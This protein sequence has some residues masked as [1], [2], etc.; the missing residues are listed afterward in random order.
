[1]I[2]RLLSPRLLSPV[3]AALLAGSLSL[4]APDPA[5]AQAPE[6][7]WAYTPPAPA[8]IPAVADEAWPANDFDRFVLA[9]LE[10]I[11]LAPAPQADPRTLVRRLSFDLLGLP[12]SQAQVDAFRRNPSDAAWQALVEEL[13]ASPHH[14]ERL[15]THWF[16]LVRFAD[17]IGIHGDNPWNVWPYRDWVLDAFRSNKPFDE[18]TIEQLAGDL[19]PD[20]TLSQQVAAAYNRLNLI[21]RE[22]G[23]QPKEF[24]IRYTADRVRNVS[25]V[26]MAASMGCCECHDHKFDPLSLREFYEFGAFFADIEQVGVYQ[27]TGPTNFKPE[28][29]VPSAEQAARQGALEQ[30]LA[31]LEAEFA[32]DSPE[33]AS[34]QQ[35]FELGLAA[36][37][38]R[39]LRPVAVTCAT[40][41][42]FEVLDDGSVLLVGE[43]PEQGTF[44]V[45]CEVPTAE[46]AALRL[47]ALAD[48]SLP[49]GGPGRAEN[50]NLVL[51]EITFELAGEALPVAAS[52]ASFEQ[53]NY[54]L[55]KALDGK[56]GRTGWALMRDSHGSAA[57][58]VFD[59]TPASAPRPGAK[60]LIRLTQEYGSQH[61]LGRFRIS[62]AT[63]PELIALGPDERD[64]LAEP[65]ATRSDAFR[66]RLRDL[67]RERTPLLAPI[68]EELAATRAALEQLEKDIPLV[69]RTRAIV[70]P[71]E[72]RVRPRGN[73]MDDSGPVVAPGVPA[74][75]GLPLAS[76]GR[77]TRLDLARWL[78]DPRHPTTARVVVNRIWRLLFGRGIVTSLDDFGLQGAAPSDLELLDHLAV[79]FV[80]SGWDLRELIRTLVRS[81]AYR[82]ASWAPDLP[83]D[84][85]NRAVHFGQQQRFRL[86]AEF[87]RDQALASSGLL[88]REVG[89]PS[90][91]PYQPPGY[92][93]HLN[94]PRRTY[95]ESTGADQYRRAV[96]THWQRQYVH[97]SMLAFDAPSRERC[98]AERQRSNTPL[99]ALA[100]LNDPSFVEA[101]RALA[102]RTLRDAPA[103]TPARLA[104][105]FGLVLQR[106]PTQREVERLTALLDR[107]LAHYAAAPA[108][109]AALLA[110]GAAPRDAS[111]DAAEH[112]AWTSVC[113]VLLNL[114][115]TIQ[116]T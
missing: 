71:M 18:F 65:A 106:A 3:R 64:A 6:P 104:H 109:A 62:S 76:D 100:A 91:F 36:Q 13:L 80:A 27:A 2:P 97:P 10:K 88:A 54:P 101:A 33:L 56:G 29:P 19:L 98:I 49:R 102:A 87:V 67:H 99:A 41:G 50:G 107:H 75:F 42:R 95:A 92:W 81:R 70:E 51:S 74:A 32:A 39:T 78:V 4:A 22:G 44:V 28:L 69:L 24:L 114:H 85:P 46:L 52:R 105:I 94:F 58:A 116:R 60:L 113:R 89:G 115:E 35:R 15:A 38:W 5:A 21:T 17:T 7:H 37:G 111:F 45:E 83:T 77:A 73:W 82:Q 8:P 84:D 16:D 12:P 72:T 66:E 23:S 9:G 63:T 59:V 57:E 86:D 40:G 26:W 53:P 93:A 110:V 55:A 48:P 30:R 108:E 43:A 90:V 103:A 14:A 11:G 25:E 112:A 47:E 68:R 79:S 34:D 20:A 1:M 61:V 96:Y 31:A